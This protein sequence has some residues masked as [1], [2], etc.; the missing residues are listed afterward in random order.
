MVG[1]FPFLFT[2]QVS[3]PINLSSRLQSK[4]SGGCLLPWMKRRADV[5]LFMW[6]GAHWKKQSG[7]AAGRNRLTWK[8]ESQFYDLDLQCD[9]GVRK[10][11]WRRSLSSAVCSCSPFSSCVWEC[12]TLSVQFSTRFTLTRC[13]FGSSRLR[14]KTFVSVRLL[15]FSLGRPI[16][17]MPI[18]GGVTI[19]AHLTLW[20]LEN[21]ERP[22]SWRWS[23]VPKDR[24]EKFVR[25]FLLLLSIIMGI[26]Q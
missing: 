6:L 19:G 1:C 10:L 3:N 22:A 9:V 13:S 17:T 5:Y 23:R 4:S 21:S 12:A 26:K 2:E 24:V 7:A 20:K 11:F 8:V 25:V 15:H 16:S 18:L 14:R